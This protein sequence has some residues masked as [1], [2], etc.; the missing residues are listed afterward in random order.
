MMLAPGILLNLGRNLTR[1][2][3]AMLK[4]I[5]SLV[6]VLMVGG[7]VFAGTVRLGGEHVC[8]MTGMM[9]ASHL[10]PA[11][12]MK[13]A[14]M[15]GMSCA[16]MPDMENMP[17]MEMSGSEDSADIETPDAE[18]TPGMDMSDMDTMP[19]CKK[20]Q[21]GA[22]P[23]EPSGVGVCCVSAPPESGST[24]A[25]FDL[26]APSFSIA[27]T[28]PALMQAPVILL[29]LGARPHVTQLFLPNL[30]ATYVRNLSFL[31]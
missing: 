8:S 31:I 7:S 12:E 20:D 2:R 6:L 29:R 16:D 13:S 25:T 24:T 15:A 4:R 18:A 11:T 19:C 9:M 21:M 17:D 22:A 23:E 30:Q 3:I 5:S 28:H 10:P 26:R 14:E 27:I 1:D